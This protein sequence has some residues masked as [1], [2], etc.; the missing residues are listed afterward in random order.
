MISGSVTFKKFSSGI[1]D[2]LTHV[3]ARSLKGQQNS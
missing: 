1:F 2:H 3:I